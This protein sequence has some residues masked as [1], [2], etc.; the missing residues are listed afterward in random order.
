MLKI[1]LGDVTACTRSKKGHAGKILEPS[2]RICDPLGNRN[3]ATLFS[4]ALN[5]ASI[6]S[7]MLWRS[8]TLRL[9]AQRS[10]EERRAYL[11][12]GL[13]WPSR[14]D[15]ATSCREQAVVFAAQGKYEVAMELLRKSLDIELDVHRADHPSADVT[16]ITM[17]ATLEFQGRHTKAARLLQ[18]LELIT[19]LKAKKRR[20]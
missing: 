11:M 18:I 2:K 15:E 20:S 1:N 17:V 6:S 5:S 12:T 19:K 16:Y 3:L 14:K 13:G 4:L 8:S 10:S 7:T 9:A